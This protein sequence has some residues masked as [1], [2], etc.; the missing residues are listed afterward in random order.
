MNV[1]ATKV[2]GDSTPFAL[3]TIILTYFAIL[4]AIR[5]IKH[6]PY[7]QIVILIYVILSGG[8][9]CYSLYGYAIEIT[10]GGR[11]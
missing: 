7:A 10:E 3:G 1:S 8:Y 2:N 6:N 4:F 9:L 11:K 5:Y